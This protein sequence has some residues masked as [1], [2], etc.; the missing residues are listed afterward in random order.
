MLLAFNVYRTEMLLNT[1]QS[2]GQPLDK[3]LADPK[4]QY[5]QVED[6]C[7]KAFRTLPGI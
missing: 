1:L 5:C 7:Y 6:L 2:P 4:C 3:E